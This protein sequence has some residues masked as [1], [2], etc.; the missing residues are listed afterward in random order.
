MKYPPAEKIGDL[1]VAAT[2]KHQMIR[3]LLKTDSSSMKMSVSFKAQRVTTRMNTII[4]TDLI[5][6]L[7]FMLINSNK[8]KCK[9]EFFGVHLRDIRRCLK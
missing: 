4:S 8:Q 6:K 7:L 2:H 5:K 3:E 1:P 9:T